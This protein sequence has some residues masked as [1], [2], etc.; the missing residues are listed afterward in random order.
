MHIYIIAHDII[1][2]EISIF[3]KNLF[4]NIYYVSFSDIII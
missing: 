3:Y 2:K 1:F 4:N